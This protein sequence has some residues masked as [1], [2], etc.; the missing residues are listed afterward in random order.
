MR[1]AL[2]AGFQASRETTFI[3]LGTAGLFALALALALALAF[4]HVAER[5]QVAGVVVTFS[6]CMQETNR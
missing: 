2:F 6:P 4:G 1:D 3:E 5:L